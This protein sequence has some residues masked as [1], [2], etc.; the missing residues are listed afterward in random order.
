M[1]HPFIAGTSCSKISPSDTHLLVTKPCGACLTGTFNTGNF[2]GRNNG[3]TNNSDGNGNS[4]GNRNNGSLN[5]NDNGNQNDQPGSGV[6]PD[7]SGT[8]A[9]KAS[10]KAAKR[11]AAA[12]PAAAQSGTPATTT[13]T[14]G[15]FVVGVG[16]PAPMRVQLLL[17]IHHALSAILFVSFEN[18]ANLQHIIPV[19]AM[20]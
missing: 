15:A 2:N 19:R 17:C 12:A 14:A 16:M 9:T 8:A 20:R 7:T 4:N 11:A 5:G 1:L 13:T 10:A 6:P 18:K 3:N